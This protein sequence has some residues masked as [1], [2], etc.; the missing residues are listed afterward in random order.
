MNY[1]CRTWGEEVRSL[2]AASR[3]RSNSEN[4]TTAYMLAAFKSLN[5]WTLLHNPYFVCSYGLFH[6]FDEQKKNSRSEQQQNASHLNFDIF[7]LSHSILIND[8]YLKKITLSPT[9]TIIKLP[10]DNYSDPV[11]VTAYI[12]M[13]YVASL[14]KSW[15]ISILNSFLWPFVAFF[16][17]NFIWTDT[18]P[19][20]NSNDNNNNNINNNK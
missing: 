13:A 6:N 11:C 2:A 12:A 14:N 18:L 17:G 8:H 5:W 10:W 9:A 1:A 16:K 19:C 3:R 15:R 7:H 20:S 4:H